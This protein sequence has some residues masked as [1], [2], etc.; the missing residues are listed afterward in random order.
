MNVT[1]M[2]GRGKQN[3]KRLVQARKRGKQNAKRQTSQSGPE[4]EPKQQAFNP[5]QKL[6][7]QNDKRATQVRSRRINLQFHKKEEGGGVECRIISTTRAP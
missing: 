3:D 6:G 5:G 1:T 2:P 7:K 4:D